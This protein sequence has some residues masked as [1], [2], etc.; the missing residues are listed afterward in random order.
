MIFTWAVAADC[1]SFSAFESSTYRPSYIYWHGKMPKVYSWEEKSRL[2]NNICLTGHFKIKGE[3]GYMSLSMVPA[4]VMSSLTVVIVINV[5]ALPMLLSNIAICCC[6]CFLVTQSF[7]TL[8]DPRDCSTPGFPVLHCLSEL[9]QIH[10]H[11]V[12]DVIQPC[13]PLSS[14]FPGFNLS[15]HQGLLK[16]VS[17]SHQVAEVLEFQLQHES[18]QW[19]F[20]TDLL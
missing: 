9:A 6:F 2:Q 13:H 16:W 11:W 8:C 1:L 5:K 17:S 18:F 7:L 20:R 19:V 10:V 15:Q 12:G 4:Q 3:N 14:P